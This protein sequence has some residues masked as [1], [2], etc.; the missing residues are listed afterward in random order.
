MKRTLFAQPPVPTPVIPMELIGTSAPLF[1][2]PDQNDK[3]I[4]LADTKGKWVVLAFYPSDGTMGWTIQNQSY[5]ASKAEFDKRNAV[6]YT[7]S[8]Q[9]TTSKR[10]FCEKAKLS[11]TLLSDMGG[12]VAKQ[13]GAL[14]VNA[15]MAAR[16]TY[17]INPQGKIIAVDTKS[18]PGIAAEVSLKMLDRLI[19]DAQAR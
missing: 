12:T 3:P 16:Y 10:A 14:G 17:Y 11:H 2:L 13:Y 5:S 4:K 6:F 7:L 15:K 9:D 19:K 18:K 8:V 1:T